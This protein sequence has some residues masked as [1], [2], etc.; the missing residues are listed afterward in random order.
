MENKQNYYSNFKC[1]D[2]KGRRVAV[3]GRQIANVVQI[4]E[5]KCS[6]LDQFNKY[7]AKRIYKMFTG[8]HPK[9]S[10]FNEYHPNVYNV[11]IT[12]ENKPLWTFNQHCKENYYHKQNFT[13]L[14][15]VE[16]L[17]KGNE[18]KIVNVTKKKVKI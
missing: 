9:L 12:G 4:F 2:R 5:L 17:I 8:E 14:F 15:N 3:F 1:Y 16:I 11:V 10:W 7:T 6:K 18:R 13:C